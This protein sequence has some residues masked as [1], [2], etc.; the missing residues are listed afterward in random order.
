MAAVVGARGAV[1]PGERELGEQVGVSRT[2][3]RKAMEDLVAEGVLIRRQGARTAVAGRLEKPLSTLTSFSEDMRARGL[4]PGMV[5]LGREVGRASATEAVA[6]D[7]APGAPVVRLR[8]LRTGDGTPMAIEYAVVPAACLPDPDEVKSSL[9]EAFD[10]RGL[11][12]ARALQRLRAAVASAE[13][14][15]LLNLD[16]GAPLLVAERRCFLA[17]GRPVEF[18][19]TRY[20]GET[21]DFVVEL[22]SEAGAARDQ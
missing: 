5:W 9:Y 13:D 17:D 21:Y 6:L 1:L 7:V 4:V 16:I 14:A 22:R 12:P 10:R 11:R 15:R 8:R 2:S 18:T 19:Q 20:A 3:V